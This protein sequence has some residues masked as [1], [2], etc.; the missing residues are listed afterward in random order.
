MKNGCSITP[1]PT[2]P[3]VKLGLGILIRVCT[4]AATRAIS[5][6]SHIGPS[7]YS[8]TIETEVAPREGKVNARGTH[9]GSNVMRF[10]VLC[11][12]ALRPGLSHRYG[13]AELDPDLVDVEIR[14]PFER[15]SDTVD[16]D[17]GSL[18]ATQFETLLD[19]RLVVRN[20]RRPVFVVNVDGGLWMS[21]W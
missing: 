1:P 9:G 6:L 17:G 19:D 16:V 13:A 15:D 18:E 5:E 8:E 7:M 10:K 3:G 11:D 21:W 2:G 20:V 12:K 4:A 14:P